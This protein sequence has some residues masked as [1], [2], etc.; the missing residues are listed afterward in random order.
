VYVLGCSLCGDNSGVG[1]PI[2]RDDRRRHPTKTCRI[3]SELTESTGWSGA[4]AG[5]VVV[6][7]VR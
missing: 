2:H 4:F 3:C 7:A 5:Q 1:K 6:P